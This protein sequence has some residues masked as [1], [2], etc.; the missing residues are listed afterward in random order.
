MEPR[1]VKFFL[2][3]YVLPV[4]WLVIFPPQSRFGQYLHF[5]YLQAFLTRLAIVLISVG[6][7]VL[8]GDVGCNRSTVKQLLVDMLFFV[9]FG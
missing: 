2:Q 6:E 9:L 7:M 1:H 3:S 8:W 5:L 4:M